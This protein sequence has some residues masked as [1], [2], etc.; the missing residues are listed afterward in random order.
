MKYNIVFF[1]GMIF[2]EFSHLIAC[3][4]FGVKVKKVKF[5]GLNEA[6]VVH[7]QP[8]VFKSIMITLA[9][10]ILGNWIAFF[11]FSFSFSLLFAGNFFGFVFLWL[12][13][14]LVHYCFP[15][16]QD[17]G[18]TF[19]AFKDFYSFNLVKGNILVKLILLI[20]IPFVF[21]PLFILL[22]LLLLFNYSYKLRLLWILC[23]FLAAFNQVLLYEFISS[24]AFF[25]DSI[26]S[27]LFS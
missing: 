16:D 13:F 14:S 11:L 7:E 9:P 25:F 23:V 4:L 8:N 22:G 20:S 17:A 2:H 10:F 15:S 5:F 19:N 24:I 1:P 3:I 12:A 21:F 26:V 18:N 6:Y 27:F